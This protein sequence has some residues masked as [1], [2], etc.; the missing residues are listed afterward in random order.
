MIVVTAIASTQNKTEVVGLTPEEIK[1][2]TP[3]FYN[4]GCEVKGL[5]SGELYC[6]SGWSSALCSSKG[7]QRDCSG[8][9]SGKFET[10]YLEK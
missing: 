3:P 4:D 10:N 2:F 7:W 1:W 9:R 5:S 8:Q 6:Y